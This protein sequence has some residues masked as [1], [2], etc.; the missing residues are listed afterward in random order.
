MSS[1]EFNLE[2][3][4]DNVNDGWNSLTAEARN[5]AFTS[6]SDQQIRNIP[7]NAAEMGMGGVLIAGG[8]IGRGP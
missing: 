7:L 1:F 5:L 4:K 2:S 6:N 3:V 8:L